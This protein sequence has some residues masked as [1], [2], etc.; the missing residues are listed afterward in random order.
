MHNW[1]VISWHGKKKVAHSIKI[2]YW[3]AFLLETWIKER[4][5]FSTRN[6]EAS[7]YEWCPKGGVGHK[8]GWNAECTQLGPPWLAGCRR[9]FCN[10]SGPWP[11]DLDLWVGFAVSPMCPFFMVFVWAGQVFNSRAVT[12]GSPEA[13]PSNND[14][15]EGGP[16]PLLM[17]EKAREQTH[18][19]AGAYWED[20]DTTWA[21]PTGLGRWGDTEATGQTDKSSQQIPMP[22]LTFICWFY[23]LAC[24]LFLP[25]C[26]KALKE[27]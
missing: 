6:I 4:C 20:T 23:F 18:R 13:N 25:F 10:S 7:R 15:T 3:V 22:N 26:G 17:R 1:R 21:T 19:K 27:N 5:F 24:F 14:E 8:L 12:G 9:K 16:V 11:G 2:K